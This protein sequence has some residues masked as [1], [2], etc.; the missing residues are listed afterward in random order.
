MNATTDPI[1]QMAEDADGPVQE[2]LLRLETL[3]GSRVRDEISNS[4]YRVLAEIGGREALSVGDLGKAIRSAQSTTSEMV[5]RLAKAGLVRK[6]RGSPGGAVADGRVVM[7]ELT[8][9]GRKMVQQYRKRVHEWSRSLLGRMAPGERDACLEA[10]Q[11]LDE[12]L[13][14]GMDA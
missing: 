8:D 14:K 9:L 3:T 4:Q 2:L 13:R 11:R 10:L 5:A 12:L 1:Q 7:I 6:L